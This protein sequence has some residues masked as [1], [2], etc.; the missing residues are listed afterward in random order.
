VLIDLSPLVLADQEYAYSWFFIDQLQAFE[1]WL[2]FSVD[3]HSP[4]QQLPVVLQVLLSQVF[5]FI[6]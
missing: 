5:H 2:K 1:I 6:L 4:P 3:K